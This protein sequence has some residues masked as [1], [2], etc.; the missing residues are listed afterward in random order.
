MADRFTYKDIV[1]SETREFPEG[2]IKLEYVGVAPLRIK[3]GGCKT[4]NEY[5]EKIRKYL[6]PNESI[7]YDG[8]GIAKITRKF[9]FKV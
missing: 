5:V 4:R 8:A 3:A 2:Q 7:D 6:L 1:D 9:S